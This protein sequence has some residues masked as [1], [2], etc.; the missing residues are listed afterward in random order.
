MVV[1]SLTAEEAAW[2]PADASQWG[3][4]SCARP[5]PGASQLGPEGGVW[6][7]P[8]NELEPG[9][10]VWF[11]AR[12]NQSSW[13]GVSDGPGSAWL[14]PANLS[15]LAHTRAALAT[16]RP[17]ES[18]AWVGA[19]W[20]TQHHRAPLFAHP[21]GARRP[22]PGGDWAKTLLIKNL[23]KRCTP[24]DV[25]HRLSWLRLEGDADYIYVPVTLSGKP[26]YNRRVPE[27]CGFAFV[28][29]TNEDAAERAGRALQQTTWGAREGSALEVTAAKVQ[30]RQ[31]NLSQFL[32]KVSSSSSGL[33]INERTVPLLRD[34]FRWVPAVVRNRW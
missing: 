16:M 25:L 32:D 4:A 13:T 15:G 12:A 26:G 1:A 17:G 3:Q 31:A 28:N 11:Q 20:P 5:P 8:A 7:A 18:A 14:P 24:A 30:G 2:P 22:V 19:P 9:G 10:G 23:D 33:T 21:P 29:F 6:P 34:G 27:G